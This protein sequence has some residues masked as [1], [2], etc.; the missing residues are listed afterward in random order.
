[1]TAEKTAPEQPEVHWDTVI[2]NQSEPRRSHLT[3]ALG[4]TLGLATAVGAISAT[5]LALTL[6]VGGVGA[7]LLH[8]VWGTADPA[9]S[10]KVLAD[11]LDVVPEAGTALLATW[12]LTAGAIGGLHLVSAATTSVSLPRSPARSWSRPPTS[13]GS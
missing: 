3:H 2:L 4:S 11:F 6:V 12:L 13:C 10:E 9:R 7:A 5:V 1:M 8:L